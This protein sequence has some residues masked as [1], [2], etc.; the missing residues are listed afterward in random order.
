MFMLISN[1]NT[2]STFNISRHLSAVACLILSL[3]V[4]IAT[5]EE[6]ELKFTKGPSKWERSLVTMTICKWALI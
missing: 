3:G 5:Q 6:G 2:Q 4:Q 1:S